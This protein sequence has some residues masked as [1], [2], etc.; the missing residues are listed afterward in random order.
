MGML[1]TFSFLLAYY[2]LKGEIAM[3]L[4]ECG[5]RKCCIQ[6]NPTGTLS[7]LPENLSLAMAYVPFQQL[8]RTYDTEQA[9]E[10]GTLFPELDKPFL[11]GRGDRK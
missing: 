9:L 10:A 8:V 3:A 1:V 2:V 6:Y 4:P 7:P 11:A 5:E